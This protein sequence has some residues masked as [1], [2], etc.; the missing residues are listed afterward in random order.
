MSP[1]SSDDE[2]GDGSAEGEAMELD[3]PLT[4]DETR[5]LAET[6]KKRY[7]TDTSDKEVAAEKVIDSGTQEMSTE[8]SGLN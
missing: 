5:R 8:G 2:E 4:A 6:W 1:H 7:S 3:R